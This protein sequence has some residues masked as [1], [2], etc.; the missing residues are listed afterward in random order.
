MAVYATYDI[1]ADG[2]TLL[3]TTP[4]D[5]VN[6]QH[7]FVLE[8]NEKVDFGRSSVLSYMVDPSS[9]GVVF[10]MSVSNLLNNGNEDYKVIIP[11][12]TLPSSHAFLRQEVIAGGTFAKVNVSGLGVHKLRIRVISGAAYFSDIVHMYLKND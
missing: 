2:K 6:N 11:S 3:N 9:S 4:N 1:V 7:D 5:A 8:F 10:E 12:T